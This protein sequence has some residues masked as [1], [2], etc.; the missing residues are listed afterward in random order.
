MKKIGIIVPY[1]FFPPMSGGA[2]RCFHVVRE[3]SPLYKIT[4]FTVEQPDMDEFQSWINRLLNVELIVIPN[5]GHKRRGFFTKMLNL[6]K[7][8]LYTEQ[9]SMSANQ[10]FVDGYSVL[11]REI[12]QKKFDLFICQNLESLTFFNQLLKK[13]DVPVLYEAHNVDSDLWK[14]F[15]LKTGNKEYQFYSKSAL[16]AEQKLW[17]STDLIITVTKEDKE[18]LMQLNGSH[19]INIEVVESGVDTKE[20]Q[21]TIKS[22][23]KYFKILFCGS[24][25]YEPNYEGLIWF[26]KEVIPLLRETRIPFMVTII[27]RLEN[28][29]RYDFVNAIPE[30]NL[31]GTVDKVNDFYNRSDVSIVPLLSGSGIRLKITESLSFEVP[32]V[33]TR[34]GAEG[35]R[36]NEA[37]IL[38]DTPSDF[39][40][41][42]KKLYNMGERRIELGTNGRLMVVNFY[43]WSSLMSI[44]NSHIQKIIK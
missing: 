44:F 19:H 18:R 31:I 35:I 6:L 22:Y 2:L 42:L 32:V 13:Y 36:P 38:A 5:T 9:L 17:R 7:F 20:K 15:Y 39:V 30:I 34:L 3:L 26:C 37:I 16:K 29:D 41:C 24:L 23:D 10:F 1:P 43:D 27:G 33:S 21:P 11:S 28:K 4:V 14:Q 8:N 40:T 25:E 12:P